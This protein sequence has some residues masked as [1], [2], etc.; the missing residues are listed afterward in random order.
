MT[1]STTLTASEASDLFRAEPERWIDVDNGEV[2]YRRVGEGPDV[3]FVHGWPVSGAT[4]RG[5]LPYLAPHVTCH[6]IDLAGA[7]S[8]RFDRSVEISIERH[9]E[10]VQSVVDE[11]GLTDLA[12]VGFDSGGMIARYA[13]ADDPRVRGW[14]LIDT[15]QPQGPSWRFKAFIAMRYVPGFERLLA[16]MT[17]RPRIRRNKMVLGDAFND[18]SLL[19]GEF[20]EFFLA[21]ISSSAERL[22]AAGQFGRNFDL[23]AF[24]GLEA[25]HRRMTAP[26]QLV[27]G[28]KDPFF[29]LAWTEEMMAAFGGKVA[30]HVIDDAKLFAHEEYPRETAEVLLPTLL[31]TAAGA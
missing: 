31:G 21:P 19:D 9:A 5:M 26:V 1:S 17:S 25:L 24:D 18:R 13:L 16:M 6:L 22:W 12:V 15:E 14:G 28:A 8:S 27:W 7:G 30:L 20:D 4:Y 23:G 3:L 10:A 2:A 29:P 11:L